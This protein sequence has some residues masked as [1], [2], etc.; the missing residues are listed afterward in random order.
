MTNTLDGMAIYR[1]VGLWA[2]QLTELAQ[3]S[4][5][6]HPLGS[7]PYLAGQNQ[8]KSKA[9]FR[10]YI[11]SPLP[12]MKLSGTNQMMWILGF[13]V[14]LDPRQIRQSAIKNAEN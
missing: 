2:V 6:F 5:H 8:Q 10:F 13:M 14:F 9:D 4:Y 12:S 3:R 11:E 1:L 7:L